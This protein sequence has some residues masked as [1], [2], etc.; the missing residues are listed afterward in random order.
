MR[1]REWDLKGRDTAFLQ[2]G[3][4]LQ[5]A[6]QWLAHAAIKE[7]KAAA[8]QAEY[9]RAS[10]EWEAGENERLRLQATRLR[11]RAW[12]IFAMMVLAFGVAVFALW[13]AALARG[14]QLVAASLSV[15]STDPELSV[16]IVAQGVAATWP[17]LH[18]VLPEAEQQLRRAI[19]ASH[20]Y[21][22]LSGHSDTIESVSWSP[23]GKRLA[24]GSLDKTAKVWDAETGKEVLTLSGH[25]DWVKSVAWSPDAKRLATGS[26]DRT[27]EVWDAGTGKEVLTLSGH[28][29]FVVSV[30]WSPDG[31]RLATTSGDKTAKVWDAG[32]GKE[33]LTL[34][35]HRN[36]V[37]SVAWSPDGKRLATASYDQTVQVYA[38]D[39]HDLMALARQRVTAHPSEGGCQEY[40]HADHCPPVPALG[41]W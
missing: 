21:L 6:M 14:R 33:E 12:A 24:T 32:M 35:G 15:E 11:R 30:A 39:I 34:S 41:W 37:V 38:M 7:P 36:S 17:A 25:S 10:R 2:R 20:V 1:A 18:T 8:L 3:I 9:V 26:D 40:L 22:T 27:A 4:D 5:N 13:Q 23:D 16:L 28:R 29:N 31:Q 19:M